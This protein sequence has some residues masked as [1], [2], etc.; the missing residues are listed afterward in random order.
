MKNIHTRNIISL[1]LKAVL[2]IASLNGVLLTYLLSP[3]LGPRVFL[4]FTIQSNLGLSIV[5]SLSFVFLLIKVVTKKVKER[6]W[7][8]ILQ[9]IFTVAISLT[10]LVFCFALAPT[11]GAEAWNIS[12]L[13]THVIAP[14]LAVGDFLIQPRKPSYQKLDFFYGTI[15]PLC[16]LC[17]ALIGYG[18]KLQFSEGQYYPYFFLNLD[19]PAGFFGFSHTLP[20]FMGTFYWIILLLG[21]VIGLSYLFQRLSNRLNILKMETVLCYIKR[22][23]NYLLML[24]NK[25]KDDINHDK[26]IGVGGHIEKGETADQCLIREVKEETNLDLLSFDKRGIILFKNEEYWEIMHVYSSEHFLGELRGCDEGTL[27]WIPQEKIEKL[28]LW[29]GDK[30]F[31]PLLLANEPYFSFILYY[32]GEKLLKVKRTQFPHK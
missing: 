8:N 21:V 14:L 10:G 22:N 18:C 2:V 1:I 23:N 32:H 6:K 27:K 5:M 13:L 25:E 24:R 15:S 28:S 7:L 17:F 31:L 26:W 29:E 20:Y 3:T 30:V 11:L 9:L 19:S 4:Y 16:Y 12:N